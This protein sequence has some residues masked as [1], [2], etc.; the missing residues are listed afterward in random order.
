MIGAS[1]ILPVETSN[2]LFNSFPELNVLGHAG[3]SGDSESNED[4]FAAILKI[5]GEESVEG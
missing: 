1:A 5:F 3:V 2:E 4:N